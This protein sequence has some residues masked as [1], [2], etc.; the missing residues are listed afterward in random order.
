MQLSGAADITLLWRVC[1]K[2]GWRRTRS[3]TRR[4]TSASP[5][6]VRSSKQPVGYVIA[7]TIPPISAPGAVSCA[8]A[9]SPFTSAP[10]SV[11][12]GSPAKGKPLSP[13]PLASGDHRDRGRRAFRA[14][15]SHLG[16]RPRERVTKDVRRP[17]YSAATPTNADLK[18]LGERELQSRPSWSTMWRAAKANR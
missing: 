5:R 3:T 6:C 12:A 15:R 1:D 17:A 13:E 2:T 4:A 10:L 11:A 16:Y 14:A 9:R 8:R 18:S 7:Q